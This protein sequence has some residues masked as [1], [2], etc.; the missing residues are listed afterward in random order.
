MKKDQL[1]GY[2]FLPTLIGILFI[3]LTIAISSCQD[4]GP[5]TVAGKL[6]SCKGFLDESAWSSAI[7]MCKDVST[8]EGW[9]LTAQAYMGRAGLSMFSLLRS[10]TDPDAVPTNLIFGYIP[11]TTADS[12][13][14]KSALDAIML[15]V[16]TKTPTMYLESLLLSSMLV[17]REM[18]LLLGLGI[19][20]T[21]DF[22][23]CAGNPP[24]VENCAFAPKI[25]TITQ[26]IVGVDVEIPDQ[27]VFG[28]LGASFYD[29]LCDNHIA[30]PT[31]DGVSTIDMTVDASVDV[32]DGANDGIMSVTHDVT[33]DGC[34][35]KNTSVLHYNKVANANFAGMSTI[36]ALSMLDF[37][38]K[39]DSG[40]NFSI[41]IA[42]IGL[43]TFCKS[44][45]IEPPA[46]NDYWLN[47]C[48]VLNFLLNPGL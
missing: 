18:K 14:Y 42:T 4:T 31:H 15:K 17:F 3:V 5:K 24:A 32:F 26:T 16:E 11:D 30:D 6:E 37:Y 20:A 36:S 46:A 47:D 33:A 35:I 48:E 34:Q 43:V 39:F 9:H 45:I 38:S 41:D 40:V 21:G 10:L 23:T 13:D 22:T 12:D 7:D 1:S 2:Q 44:G 8:D 28:G 29:N 19:D 27:L 25:T